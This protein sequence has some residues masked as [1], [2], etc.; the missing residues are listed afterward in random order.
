MTRLKLRTIKKPNLDGAFENNLEVDSPPP[1]IETQHNPT[2]H[3]ST[4]HKKDNENYTPI[5]TQH[6]PTPHNSTQHKKPPI[7]QHDT[8]LRHTKPNTTKGYNQLGELAKKVVRFLCEMALTRDQIPYFEMAYRELAEQAEISE[9][10]IR[11][12]IARL[13][14]EK[15]LEIESPRGGR[16]AKV[17]IRVNE[18][19]YQSY[20]ISKSQHNPTQL[21]TKPNTNGPLSKKEE[22]ILTYLIPEPLK[23]IGLYE[24]HLKNLVRPKE[25][26]EEILLHFSHSVQAN[27]IKS[28]NKLP[29]LLSILKDPNKTWVSETYL[30]ALE[31]EF[32]K[33]AE[34][35][36]KLKQLNTEVEE[37]KLQER[38]ELFKKSNPT[39]YEEVRNEARRNFKSDNLIEIHI[40]NYVAELDRVNNSPEV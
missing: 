37:Q 21:N 8:T 5:E 29:V 11:T 36:S 9:T 22:I 25:Q 1:L 19:I 10:S 7:T 38:V 39:K 14:S 23:K 15:L 28:P 24:A 3:N 17:K 27:E 32:K 6:N 12:T 31:V 16:S 40:K 34:R 30:T 35:L 26:I 20:L 2:P 13:K 4:Q 18:E 33:N